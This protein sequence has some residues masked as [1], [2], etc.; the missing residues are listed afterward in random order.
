MKRLDI[1]DYFVLASLGAMLIAASVYL[2]KHPSDINYA[3]WGA[4]CGTL[5]SA[6]H[7]LAIGDDK[8]KDDNGQ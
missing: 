8:R 1:R 2:F 4:V 6:Y 3:A 5:V 7:W